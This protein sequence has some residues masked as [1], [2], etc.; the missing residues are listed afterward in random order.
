[1]S[2]FNV[3]PDLLPRVFDSAVKKALEKTADLLSNEFD[4]E[5]DKSKWPWERGT[6]VRKAR[7]PVGSPRDIVD[8]S[9]LKNSKKQEI[10]DPYSVKWTWEV[11]YSAIV[12]NGGQFLDGTEYPDRP[13]TRDAPKQANI[14]EYFADI[15]RREI[16]G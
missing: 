6:T 16:D 12:H 3:P 11:D 5:I 8:T 10:I 2:R 14:E 9:D 1:M 7:P 15:L 13:W 4:K